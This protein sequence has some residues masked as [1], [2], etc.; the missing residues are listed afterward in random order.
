[1]T[2]LLVLRALVAF[3]AVLFACWR[4]AHAKPPQCTA[5]RRLSWAVWVVGHVCISTGGL[6]FAL[7]LY[8]YVAVL[9]LTGVAAL[10]SLHIR[11]RLAPWTC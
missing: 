1:M 10:T 2:A 6:A 9:A 4:L 11:V 3:L 7:G 5:L 8:P